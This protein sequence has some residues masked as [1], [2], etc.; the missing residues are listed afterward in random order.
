MGAAALQ[1]PRHVALAAPQRGAGAAG[2]LRPVAVGYFRIIR[3]S[4]P[5]LRACSKQ[6][7]NRGRSLAGY[8]SRS[9]CMLYLLEAWA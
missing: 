7:L 4:A 8:P 2:A 5:A 9:E 3:G 6:I 1:R